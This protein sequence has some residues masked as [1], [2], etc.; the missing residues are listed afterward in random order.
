MPLATKNNALIVK[1]GLLAENCGCCGGWYC[2]ADPACA[3]GDIKTATISITASDYYSHFY[4]STAGFTDS[5]YIS[6]GTRGAV[7]NGTHALT[8]TTADGAAI[9]RFSKKIVQF[10]ND[11]CDKLISVEVSRFDLRWKIEYTAV[12]YR[13]PYGVPTAQKYRTLAEMDCS[14]FINFVPGVGNVEQRLHP[15]AFDGIDNYTTCLPI[16]GNVFTPT[17]LQWP[18]NWAQIGPSSEFMEAGSRTLTVNSITLGT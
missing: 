15:W 2:C 4:A 12:T 10:G 6:L 7:F 5:T 18:L 11:T 17:T 8:R 14:A 16:D 3:V 1:D 9:A 13:A